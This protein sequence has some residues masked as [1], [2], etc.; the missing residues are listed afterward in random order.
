M[1]TLFILFLSVFS[2]LAKESI[3]ILD[4]KGHTGVISDVLVTNDKRQII[5]ASR[6]K[7]VRVWNS[8]TGEEVRKILG[9]IGPHH[10][11]K[12]FAIALSPDNRYLAVGGFFSYKNK[13]NYGD[14]RIY[15]YKT[16]KMVERVMKGTH[17]NVILDLDYSDDGRYLISSSYD[18]TVKVWDA[19]S[20]YRLVDTLDFHK[21]DVFNAK[22]KKFGE[23]YIIYSGGNS[24]KI[25]A[26]SLNQ[27][28]VVASYDVGYY[29]RKIE[30][31]KYHIAVGGYGKQV[32]VFDHYLNLVKVIKTESRP[33]GLAYSPDGTLL[34]T[35]RAS[36]PYDV[37]VYDAM[38]NYSLIQSFKKHTNL[39]KSMAFVDDQTLVSTGG[40]DIDMYI[41]NIKNREV[42]HHIKGKGLAVWN[43]GLKGS[44]IA[45]GNKWTTSTK[46][47]VR[48]QKVFD[49]EDHT[50]HS[51]TAGFNTV[52]PT[53]YGAYT[54]Q[55]ERGGALNYKNANLLL[56]KDG[57][58]IKRI[59]R[60]TTNGL[61]HTS[62]GFYKNYIISAGY[63]GVITAYDLRGNEVAS[64]VGHTGEV[65]NIAFDQD[66]LV[67]GSDDQSIRVWDLKS[68]GKEKE[69]KPLLNLFVSEDNEWIIWNDHG[70]YD[71][72]IGGDKYVGYHVNQGMGKEARF[73]TSD[74]FY[75]E[76]YK[77]ALISKTYDYGDYKKALDEE[78]KEFKEQQLN[79]ADSLPPVLTLLSSDEVDTDEEY[80]TITFSID[81]QSKIKRLVVTN[82]GRKVNLRALK[83]AGKESESLRVDV[84][85]GTNIIQIRAENE[86]A[87]SDPITVNV[88]KSNQLKDIY[89]PDLYVLS[90]GVSQ[91]QNSHYNLQY[92]HKD[93]KAIV[94]MFNKQKVYKNVHHKLLTNESA[95]RDN[96][97][98]A[99]DWVNREATQR[100]VVIIFLAGH[101]VNDSYGSYYF[102]NYDANV[103]YLRKTAVRWAE[104][105]DVM[106]NLPSKV[107]LLADTCHSGNIAGGG[108]RDITGAIKSILSTGVG[109][110]IMT[111]TTG[112]GYSYEDASWGH[113]AFTKA[114]IEGVGNSKA[115]YDKDGTITVKEI[116]LF[117]TSHVKKLTK[118]KQKPTT[119]VPGS[120]PDF[121]IATNK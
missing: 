103:D 16:G 57:Q 1:K 49:L 75:K 64:F 18:D 17:N 21:N 97:L 81:S 86:S 66:K 45:I 119:I 47:S 38:K 27:K 106:T 7:T 83:K 55:Q 99:L 22:I 72:S 96:I 85:N 10:D 34:A 90:I 95:S 4:T 120:I 41:W 112:S 117:I 91:Y 89:K 50:F 79:V 8:K 6:D 37:T 9:Q 51:D 52:M 36:S 68:M 2:L 111:A 108:K 110:V 30:V 69:I 19:W 87:L 14:I 88:Y 33:S 12:V 102:M 82:N 59:K 114:F 31:G 80:V 13:K 40:S 76:K 23:D 54:L 48:F 62:Y 121:A 24:K 5:T 113:G 44:Q 116:D 42:K 26:Y 77:P 115:D 20:N 29:I 15:D 67:S 58:L 11:G 73:V 65:W 35:G 61:G 100:D 39:I 46:S 74:K 101:G 93:A 94:D 32:N 109:Q 53:T 43:V 56:K 25:Y 104:F 60:D 92:A 71:S 70:Y 107:I 84:Q 105:Q 28:S 63:H 3:L 118:G 78:F 98:D